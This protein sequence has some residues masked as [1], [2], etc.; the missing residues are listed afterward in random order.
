MTKIDMANGVC[1]RISQYPI[2]DYLDV[3]GISESEYSYILEW[4]E[5]L[6]VKEHRRFEW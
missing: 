3:V 5:D 6:G 2:G 1:P 4:W